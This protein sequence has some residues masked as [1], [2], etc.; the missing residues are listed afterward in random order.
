MLFRRFVIQEGIPT[1]LSWSSMPEEECEKLF[2]FTHKRKSESRY[3]VRLSLKDCT[4]QFGNSRA[5]AQR[6]LF[7]MEKGF[8]KD[9][10]LRKEL[11]LLIPP[12]HTQGE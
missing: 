11:V 9:L 1:K 7:Q 8:L 2:F 10:E 6:A 5:A 12:L 4:L 3:V